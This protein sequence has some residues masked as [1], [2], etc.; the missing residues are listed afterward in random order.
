MKKFDISIINHVAA[1]KVDGDTTIEAVSAEVA[2][3]LALTTSS[4]TIR[5]MSR[6]EIAFNKGE[7]T[8]LLYID[9]S[10]DMMFIVKVVD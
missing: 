8:K 1:V 7:V 6:M 4:A 10:A 9:E 2:L 3:Q 5:G